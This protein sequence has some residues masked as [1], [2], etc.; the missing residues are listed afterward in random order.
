[1]ALFPFRRRRFGVTR[2]TL[3][4]LEGIQAALVQQNALLTRLADHLAPIGEAPSLEPGTLDPP[5]SDLERVLL[6]E[7]SD[8][9]QV[10]HGRP[11]SDEELLERLTEVVAQ[12]AARG[13][14]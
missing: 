4:A 3:R 6:E 9:Y 13:V 12:Q 11:P 7:Y 5:L 8:Q 14:R 10:D 2:R 1:M